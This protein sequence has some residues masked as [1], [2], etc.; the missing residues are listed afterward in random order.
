[1][2]TSPVSSST[3]TGPRVIGAGYGRTG[4][5]SLKRAL[6]ILGFGPCHHMEEVVKNPDEVPTWEAAGRGEAVD[7]ATFL[8]GWGST[9]DFPSSFYYAQLM[10][11]FPDAKVILT[12]RDPDAWCDSFAAT[13]YPMVTRFP[14]RVV[15]PW[16]PRQG[17]S[18]L[19]R[20]S[21]RAPV[22]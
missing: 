18:P 12:K 20:G 5:A 16:L 17:C 6:E 4:T 1:M 22:P 3:R 14:K 8:Q 7:W 15:F 2:S 9:C 11:A 21:V 10:E 13:I 19:D